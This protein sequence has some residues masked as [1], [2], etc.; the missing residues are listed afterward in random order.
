MRPGAP[1]APC[2]VWQVL[3]SPL[4]TALDITRVL[5]LKVICARM[6]NTGQPPLAE[7]EKL[8]ALLAVNVRVVPRASVT[9]TTALRAALP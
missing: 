7:P 3:Q 4:F 2:K 5:P 8:P 1:E 9:L 6:G